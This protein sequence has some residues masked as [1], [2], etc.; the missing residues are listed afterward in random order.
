MTFVAHVLASGPGWRVTDAVCSAGPGDRPFEERHDATCIALVLRGSF[1]YRTAAGAALMAP[2]AVM[3]GNPGQGF[4]CHHA[5]GRGDRCLA[6]HFAPESWEAVLAAVPGVRH[7][8]FAV[9]RLPPL[10]ALLPLQAAAEAARDA[11]SAA[12]LEEIGLDLAAAVA[13][14]LAGSRPA[15]A[16]PGRADAARVTSVL[17]SIEA[18]PEESF[19]VAAMAR[20]A[21]M[22]AYHFLRVFRAVA[23]VT[24]HQH[25]LRTRLH[26]AALRLAAGDAPVSAVAFDL[27]FNDLSTFNRRFRRVT[28]MTPGAW[29]AGSARRLRRPIPGR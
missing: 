27:G 29:R 14:A 5:H 11:G 8:A 10:P 3:L 2:G 9:P 18:A 12:A 1:E 16:A 25:L 23:G 24:P 21:G 7:A 19:P 20:Q 17:R 15:A 26:R 22:S 13:A 6:F 28:G 4:E